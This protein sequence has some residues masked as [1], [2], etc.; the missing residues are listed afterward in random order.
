MKGAVTFHVL[1]LVARLL[2]FLLVA[3][4]VAWFFLIKQ[5]G[6]SSFSNEVSSV[7]KEKLRVEEIQ[8]Q[9]LT[10]DHGEFYVSRMAMSGGEETFFTVMEA[11]NLK[12]QM[13]LLDGFRKEWSPGII[14]ISRLDIGLRA[15]ADS[16]EAAKSMADVLFQASGKMKLSTISVNDA[17]LRWGYSER[18][19]GSIL[20]SKMQA[21][22]TADGWK[23]KFRGGNFT[24]NWLKRL[25]IVELDV[26]VSKQ[27][28]VFEKALFKKNTGFVTLT[29]IRVKAGER[30]EVSG[31]MNL[32]KID[33][34]SLVPPA[35][36]N[37]V[38]GTVS[39]E[40]KVFGSTNSTEGVG[41]EGEVILAG[42]DMVVVRDKVHLLRAL[43]VADAFNNYG[44]VDFREGSFRMRTHGGKLQLTDVQI[45]AGD[46]FSI[47]GEM[48]ARLPTADEVIEFNSAAALDGSEGILNDDEI[49][50]TLERA[51]KGT[52]AGE[53]GFRKEGDESLFDRLGL[54]LESLRLEQ[55]AAERLAQ[56]CRYEGLFT[57]TLPKDIFARSPKLSEMYP[58]N[59]ANGRVVMD[60]PINGV[61]YD[62]T[63][64]Q[65][66]EIYEK[67]AP[68]P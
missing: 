3:T 13:G 43:S 35:V 34:S 66:N 29:D 37:F 10:R 8:L 60:V 18:T 5:V 25:E 62:I 24:Q 58:S 53:V 27:G 51:A 7:L 44:R 40:F 39:G 26:A 15:G 23:L 9:G 17:S 47:K 45:R 38:E 31:M 67:G 42:E 12:C 49:D 55:N 20:G 52:A 68:S 21:Q 36:R 33:I 14:S 1:R 56:A 54:S 63:Q 64:E 61:I 11:R 65:A 32:R 28:V 2:V 48:S 41:F 30:P 6:S 4:G 50:I 16:P 57:I 19:R 22:K 59:G 46:L